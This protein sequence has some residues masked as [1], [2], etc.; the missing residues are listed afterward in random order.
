MTHLQKGV[1]S[2]TTPVFLTD[3]SE[4]PH[5]WCLTFN[6]KQNRLCLY[7]RYCGRQTQAYE[8]T[9]TPVTASLNVTF[10]INK[11]IVSGG[12]FHVHLEKFAYAKEVQVAALD[13]SKLS[14]ELLEVRI[15]DVFVMEIEQIDPCL[16]S[17][18]MVGL[19]SSMD[20][21]MALFSPTFHCGESF[22]QLSMQIKKTVIPDSATYK[23][24]VDM[25][26]DSV[27]RDHNE[28][29]QDRIDSCFNE[30]GR[31]SHYY[32]M[33]FPAELS[34][35]SRKY[36]HTVA[37]S[38]GLQHATHT[39]DGQRQVW[40]YKNSDMIGDGPVDVFVK[41]V[42]SS[43]IGDLA[44]RVETQSMTLNHKKCIGHHF[45]PSA[46]VQVQS[47]TELF[48]RS[49]L[50]RGDRSETVFVKLITTAKKAH[51]V[52]HQTDNNLSSRLS[53]QNVAWALQQMKR[54][55]GL[56]KFS[57][58][59]RPG[60]L[61]RPGAAPDGVLQLMS[62]NM[63]LKSVKSGEQLTAKGECVSEYTLLAS[64]NCHAVTEHEKTKEVDLLPAIVALDDFLYGLETVHNESVF[65][66]DACDLYV[67][68]RADFVEARNCSAP[69]DFPAPSYHTI[70]LQEHSTAGTRGSSQNRLTKAL[71]SA[72]L[73]DSPTGVAAHYVWRLYNP[74]ELFTKSVHKRPF[75]SDWFE[76]SNTP[77]ARWRLLLIPCIS[78][79]ADHTDSSRGGARYLLCI[80][81]NGY[82]S[83]R[84]GQLA[85]GTFA[86]KCS[87]ASTGTKR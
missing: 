34:S 63:K 20:D 24:T 21:D 5:Q 36:V 86:L 11:Q 64:G 72:S 74:K 8:L 3:E 28:T 40:C 81:C 38:K 2:Y 35:A 55:S 6:A 45:C 69:L 84:T 4:D 7:L 75:A 49:D 37:S 59:G 46:P 33:P 52:H 80:G 82:K 58:S 71:V 1:Q 43:A 29:V 39:F 53:E 25:I 14:S 44:V 70:G 56:A 18:R 66:S 54:Q 79:S 85:N 47:C 10:A 32:V 17:W 73:G 13:V 61:G 27:G 31:R 48:R 22:H 62:E 16:S 19:N 76:V 67:L 77:N 68:S 15:L 57:V 65:S 87:V 83:L 12:T 30:F 23:I 50:Y 41:I 9:S 42:D 51:H 78:K 26:F 60:L